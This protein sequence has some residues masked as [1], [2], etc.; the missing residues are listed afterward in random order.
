MRK[1][2]KIANLDCAACA[3]EL[4]EEL[5]Q[6]KGLSEV[7]VDFVGQRVGFDYDC[8]QALEKAVYAISHF[9]E[10][11]IIDGNAPEKKERH[12]KEIISI[13]VS[14]AFFLPALIMELVG[15]I[16]EWIV[17][18]LY[19]CA[20]AAA[21]WSVLFTVVKNVP[22][23]FRGGFHFGLLLDE[24]LL[25][26][27]AAAGAFALRQNMEGAIVLLLYQ[28]GELLQSLAVGSSRGAIRKLMELKSDSAI[29]VT[30]GGNKEVSPEELK[31]GDVILLRK[32]DK[33]PADCTLKDGET[34][35]DVKSLTGEAYYR[36]V[37]AGEEMLAGS[38]NAGEAVQAVVLRPS[39]ESAVAKILDL[40]ENASSQ[41]AQPE[42]FITRFARWYTPIVVLCALVL[43]IVPPLVAGGGRAE[44]SVWISRALNFLV[45]SC[46]CALIIS[47]PLTYFSGVGS[48]ARAGVLAKGAVYLD[49]L[50]SVKVAAF[51][52]TGTLTEGKF[53]VAGVNGGERVLQ[54]AAAAE[55]NSSHP[56]SQAFAGTDTPFS[57]EKTEEIAGKGIAAVVNGK[58]VL[59]GSAKLFAE[60]GVAFEPVQTG[61]LAVYVAEGGSF[62]G[63]VEITDG[64]KPNAAEAIAEL[65][66]AGV[67]YTAVLTGDTKERAERALEGLGLSEICA[68]LLPEQKPECA[69]RLKARGKMMYVGDGINDTPVMAESDVSVSMGALG[70]GA[71][72]EAS[73]LVLASDNLAAL[74]K[75]VRGAKK[76][77]KIV[78]EN[79][80]FS[81]AVKAALMALTLFGWIPL[82]AAVLG[83]VG[84][85][86]LAVLNSLR[87]RAK[88]K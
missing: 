18:S 26:L 10:V 11:E 50:A 59:V 69:K 19:I 80:V 34:E 15:G 32:G 2:I 14:L 67:A 86:L 30:D 6:I 48:L 21:G 66:R 78:T 28:I 47:V 25:M 72:I 16:N 82:W 61:N 29:L 13:A 54:L 51:D 60:R 76:T 68:E 36:E 46:P 22:K 37:R 71:A 45:I 3:A 49:T 7:S 62:L 8:A 41:K 42:K 79:I 53:S 44:F 23:A 43:A 85:M 24:N 20:F 27:V 1:K 39:S 75:A 87:M 83:D 12:F 74:P 70:S 58:E 31:A 35:L 5:S 33:L 56:L 9:E 55:Q 88:I 73:D 84:V 63:S 65:K 4:E 57:C 38:V 64:L 81:I 40:V 52:K 77:R 17:F